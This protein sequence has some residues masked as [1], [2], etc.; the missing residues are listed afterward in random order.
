[1][2]TA[3]NQS[4]AK[5]TNAWLKD[6][7]VPQFHQDGSSGVPATILRSGLFILF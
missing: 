2:E 4:K 5:A 6:H 1:M 3:S 7:M